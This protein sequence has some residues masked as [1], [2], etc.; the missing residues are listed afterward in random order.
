[1]ICRNCSADIDP[2]NER[3]PYCR[4][5]PRKRNRHGA[6]GIVIVIVLLLLIAASVFIGFNFDEVK[7]KVFDILPPE[8]ISVL[9]P[10]DSDEE[11][12]KTSNSTEKPSET[13]PAEKVTETKATT[14]ATTTAAKTTSS[15]TATAKS[16]TAKTSTTKVSTTKPAEKPKQPKTEKQFNLL[17]AKIKEY[18]IRT[19]NGTMVSKRGLIKAEK[20]QLK[21]TSQAKFGKFCL[22]KVS[23]SPYSWL[24][25]KFSDST[26][27]VFTGNCAT[28][29][30]YCKLGKDDY[31]GEV[32]GTV[33]LSSDG[34]YV[35]SK[36]KSSY[37]GKTETDTA[38]VLPTVE[39]KTNPKTETKQSYTVNKNALTEKTSSAKNST[40]TKAAKESQKSSSYSVYITDS[41]KK[42][43]KAGCPALSKS[44][45][46]ISLSN[47]KSKGYTACKRCRP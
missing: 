11:N 13:K 35:Y 39:S 2:Q 38:T 5:D 17:N 25:I 22:Q 16:T 32:L 36:S 24:T 44:K 47:A 8:I 28:S 9:S 42:Y 4:K 41:G 18:P 1:M 21:N 40:E 26:G 45:H 23:R 20:E 10:K 34:K 46:E 12:E 7:K 6:A 33:I 37:A 31:I 29:A 3:C 30:V 15:K 19:A 43:H 14:A 27:L